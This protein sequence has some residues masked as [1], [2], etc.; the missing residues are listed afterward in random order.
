MIWLQVL[1]F[2]WFI[3]LFSN[4]EVH[5]NHSKQDTYSSR[6]LYWLQ[7]FPDL[8]LP[9]QLIFD[10]FEFQLG[11]LLQVHE[12]IK[13]AFR[14][15]QQISLWFSLDNTKDRV[16]KRHL[17]MLVYFFLNWLYS[18]DFP[19]VGLLLIRYHSWNELQPILYEPQ[20]FLMAYQ[21][22]LFLQIFSR[23]N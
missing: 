5:S 23:I 18:K 7:Q 15:T 21:A 9:Y 13:S 14:D 3:F 1:S 12:P 17:L 2:S 6:S 16:S 8:L 10:F 22:S 11:C 20:L 4:Q 19:N